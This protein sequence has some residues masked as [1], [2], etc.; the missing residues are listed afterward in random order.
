MNT[1]S[2]KAIIQGCYW[3][4]WWLTIPINNWSFKQQRQQLTDF[5][6]SPFHKYK[7]KAYGFILVLF[8]LCVV[9]TPSPYLCVLLVPFQIKHMFPF[10]ESYES[11]SKRRA[12]LKVIVTLSTYASLC[13]WILILQKFY[14]YPLI[15]LCLMMC[16]EVFVFQ[17]YLMAFFNRNNLLLTLDTIRVLSTYLCFLKLPRSM[18]W[19]NWWFYFVYVFL[20][21][22]LKFDSMLQRILSF[23]LFS[24]ISPSLAWTNICWVFFSFFL[25][26]MFISK[27]L[28][29]THKHFNYE[30]NDVCLLSLFNLC[31]LVWLFMK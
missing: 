3:I 6:V 14:I 16:I 21:L 23:F 7:W 27:T 26:F 29:I 11:R 25:F 9:P 30:Q 15:N 18:S 1:D 13:T 22:F 28:R 24:F 17:K 19:W 4:V 20:F 31:W 5:S 8:L 12:L 10:F 2:T